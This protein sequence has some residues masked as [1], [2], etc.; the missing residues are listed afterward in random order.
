M[1]VVLWECGSKHYKSQ[2]TAVSASEM[3]HRVTVTELME[4]LGWLVMND[5]LSSPAAVY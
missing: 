4:V 5:T 2:N 1:G 3:Y